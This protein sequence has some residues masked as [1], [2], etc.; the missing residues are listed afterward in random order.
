M[1]YQSTNPYDG[2]VVKSFDEINDAELEGKLKTAS[3]CFDKDWRTRSFADRAAIV[4]RAAALMRERSQ[5]L[6]ELITLE[7]GKLIQQSVGEVA[8]SAA[9]LDYYAEHAEQF[10][11]PEK[12]TTPKGEAMVESSPIGVL[13]GVEPWNYPYYQIA[14]F[15]APNLMAGNVVMV[16]HASSVPQCALAF[17]QL[18]TDA[19]APAGAYTNLFVSKDQVAKII[20]DPRIRAVALTGSEAAGAVVAAQAGKQLKKSTMELGGSDAFI[21]LEDADLDKAVKH[22]VSGRMGNS[23]QACTASKRFIVVEPL[24]D[25]FLKKFQAAL[26]NFKPGDPMDKQT[27]L[28][29]LSSAEALKKLVEQVDGAV[30]GGARVLMGGQR[31]EGQT[32]AFMQ[33]TI[34]T[35][36]SNSNPAYKEEFFGPVALFFKVAD[37]DAAVALANDSPFGLGG[38]VFTQDIERGKRVARKIDTGMVFIN[39]GAVSSPELPFGGVKNSGYGREL[40]GAGIQEFVNKKLIRVS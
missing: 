20:D 7:M 11:A 1:A 32:G 30:A 38:S 14:R 10:L 40:S 19:G 29:P 24:A 25:S 26:E 33:P 18:M 22:A 39:S 3:A 12:L 17:E 13:F 27:T 16:K 31:I 21:V 2:K 34:L 15:A 6:A 8:L 9:I 23:G 28:A 37:E 35:D 5:A 36:I 4:K